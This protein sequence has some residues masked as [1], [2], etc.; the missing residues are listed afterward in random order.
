MADYLSAFFESPRDLKQ[1]GVKG[2][3]WYQRRSPAELA[4]ARGASGAK[5]EGDSTKKETSSTSAPKKPAGNIQ[6]NVESSSTRYARLDAQ[7]KSGRA[8]DMTEQDLKFYNARTDAL[9]K[10]NKLNQEQPSWLRET[11]TT[12]IQTT[13]QRQMQAIANSLADKY[14]GNPIKDAMGVGAAAAGSS[15]K[16]SS[17]DEDDD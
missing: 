3:K 1:Y 14:V 10:I 11:A 2:M 16:K 9:A 17:D 6:D 7:A 4:K 5:K 13:A 15:K 8:S 12:V